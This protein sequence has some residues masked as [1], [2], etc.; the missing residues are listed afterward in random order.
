MSSQ[1]NGFKNAVLL[2]VLI[3]KTVPNQ[4]LHPRLAR[5]LKQWLS[6]ARR[7]CFPWVESGMLSFLFPTH[8]SPALSLFLDYL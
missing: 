7:V 2:G 8:H 1:E 3:L 5:R 4:T 6:L